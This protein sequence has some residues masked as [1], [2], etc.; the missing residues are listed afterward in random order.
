MEEKHL[1]YIRIE[2]NV[3]MYNWCHSIQINKKNCDF[4]VL[5]TKHS[6]NPS[7]FDPSTENILAE[8]IFIFNLCLVE[9]STLNHPNLF[10][11][12]SLVQC[13]SKKSQ[14]TKSFIGKPSINE[15]AKSLHE[16]NKCGWVRLQAFRRERFTVQG[17]K[18]VRVFFFCGE[19]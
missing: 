8:Q 18:C 17:R 9:V 3:K 11:P 2:P 7:V 10:H 16:N 12:N 19:L 6:I 13:K 14:I 15:T 5:Y 1:L 4:L